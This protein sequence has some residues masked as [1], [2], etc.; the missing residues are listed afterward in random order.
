MPS[1]LLDKYREPECASSS[2]LPA[3]KKVKDKRKTKNQPGQPANKDAIALEK[4]ESS[5]ILI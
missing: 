4:V 1:G 2:T 3:G 5:A